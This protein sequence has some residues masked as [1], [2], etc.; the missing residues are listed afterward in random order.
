MI[1]VGDL[2]VCRKALRKQKVV[3]R[4]LRDMFNESAIFDIEKTT[5]VLLVS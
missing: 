3:L 1:V 4:E 2:F 5:A